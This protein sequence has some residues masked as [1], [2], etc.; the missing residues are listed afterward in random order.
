MQYACRYHPP[1]DV[2][3]CILRADPTA[4]SDQEYGG[5]QALH[6]ACEQ[7]C[8]PTVIKYLLKKYPKAAE[9]LDKDERSPFLLA[10]KSYLLK[11]NKSSINATK[12]LLEVLK[13]LSAV[14]PVSLMREDCY[15]MSGLEFLLEHEVDMHIISSVQLT[16]MSIREEM[17]SKASMLTNN[18]DQLDFEKNLNKKQQDTETKSNA[19]IERESIISRAL[20]A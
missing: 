4:I 11:S 10:C 16:S 5:K 14:A 20:A 17:D 19:K 6:I 3:K 15:G 12:D 9:K 8:S 2:V 18:M 7:G 13:M 1:L